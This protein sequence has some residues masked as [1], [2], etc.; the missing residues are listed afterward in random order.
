MT[1]A[2]F[3]QQAKDAGLNYAVLRNWKQPTPHWGEFDR[4]SSDRDTR[5]DVLTLNY[6]ESFNDFEEEASKA[7]PES[8][9]N[10][11]IYRS[12]NY[13]NRNAEEAGT[14]LHLDINDILHW[15][16]RGSTMW[17]FGEVL[18]DP[19]K[20]HGRNGSFTGETDNIFLEPGD[21]IWLRGETWHETENITEKRS[22]VFEPGKK[23]N[24]FKH[25]FFDGEKD[26]YLNKNYKFFDGEKFVVVENE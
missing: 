20:E 16:C 9:Y 10:F 3:V 25:H 26:V 22:L 1:I 7:Y 12:N 23:E 11:Y 21:L 6:P 13:R 2:E 14:G 17:K 15:Q 8:S 18:E 24:F 4:I 19:S 5:I